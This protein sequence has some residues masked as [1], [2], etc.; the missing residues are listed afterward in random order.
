VNRNDYERIRTEAFYNFHPERMRTTAARNLIHF[1]AGFDA[2][3]QMAQKLKEKK[4]EVKGCN[5][6]VE[7]NG[8]CKEHLSEAK[9]G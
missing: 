5:E 8:L 2:G 3:F 9:R 6:P 1:I 7:A 4:C